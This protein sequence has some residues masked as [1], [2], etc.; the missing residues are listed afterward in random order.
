LQPPDDTSVS[1]GA[2]DAHSTSA[3]V[4]IHFLTVILP[5][6]F[7]TGVSQDRTAGTVALCRKDQPFA[8]FAPFAMKSPWK[9][10]RMV[11]RPDVSSGSQR[12]KV[13]IANRGPA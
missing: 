1:A 4:I 5:C 2:G 3:A 10:D 6:G 11:F 8:A 12:R 13:R 7:R 9:S